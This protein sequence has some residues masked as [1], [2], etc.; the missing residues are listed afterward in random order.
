MK[1]QHDMPIGARLLPEGGVHFTLWAPAASR[2][3]LHHRSA[4]GAG[5]MQVPARRDA[6]GFW[7]ATVPGAGPD[8]LYQWQADDGPLVPDPASRSNPDGPH[9]PSR[10]TDPAAFDWTTEGW[11]GR[12]WSDTVLYELHVGTFTPE[13]TFAAATERLPWL[14]EQ[15][16]TAVELMPVATFGGRHGWGYDG[17]LPFA[18]HPAYG[19]PDDMKRFIDRAHALGL[20]VFLDVVYNHFGPDGNYLGSYAP[21][22]F[23]ETHH[24]PW[25]AAINFDGKDSGPVRE[26]FIQNA[27]YWVR[28][29]RIDGLR[30]D[31]VHAIVDDGSP[32]VLEDLAQRVRQAT[33]GRHVHLV[34]EN[35]K[36]ESQRLAPRPEPTRYDAQWNDDFHHALHVALT[37][38]RQGYYADYAHAPLDGLA[39]SFAGGYV[40]APSHRDGDGRRLA[41]APAAPQP[42]ATMVNFCGN[43]DQIGNRAFGE[44]LSHLVPQPAAELALL[45]ALLTPATP[46]VFMGDEFGAET[47]F[48]YFADWTGELREAVRQGRQREFRLEA[49]SGRELPDPCD[50]ATLERSRLDWR[51][52]EGPAGQERLALVR[53]ALAAR[54]HW[55]A[56]RLSRLRS[57][58]HTARRVGAAGLQVEWDYDDGARLVM[59]M[60]L[61]TESVVE[62][63]GQPASAHGTPVF[64]HRWDGGG[65]WAPWSARW[66]LQEVPA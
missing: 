45:S 27:L 44:R 26:F 30:L 11:T 12:P 58:T 35:E 37:G 39:H 5:P 54:R 34:L 59:Q 8:T 20:M 43:H 24:S 21:A 41:R 64:Q 63:P 28:E 31:A 57:G 4:P 17:V 46:L 61:G 40:F 48:L 55:I 38:E 33:A 29:F 1:H 62:G 65:T 6:D 18:P 16:F 66:M 2:L 51:Q 3:T 23:S 60:N 9:G 53:N 22:F 7:Q 14:A 56:P 52:A 15:G 36:N 32:H 19:T 10:V 13:G 47:P 49:G 25:G 42:L 50:A